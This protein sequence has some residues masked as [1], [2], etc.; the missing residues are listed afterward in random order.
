MSAFRPQYIT[1]YG[2][3]KD[4]EEWFFGRMQNRTHRCHVIVICIMSDS[5]LSFISS[6]WVYSPPLGRG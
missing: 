5:H 4:C 3:N 1:G 2:S 6:L